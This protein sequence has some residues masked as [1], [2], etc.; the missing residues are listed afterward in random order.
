LSRDAALA[1][2]TSDAAAILEMEN[3]LGSLEVGKLG[4][5]VVMTGPFDHAQS[6]VRYLLV[7]G[8][9]FEYNAKAKPVETDQG[10]A[11]PATDL[12]GKWNLTIDSAEGKVVAVLE[13][14]QKGKDLRGI[15]TSEQ[16]NGTLTSGSIVAEQ[17]EFVVAIGAGARTIRLKFAGLLKDNKLAGE[18]KA[19][20]GAATKWRAEREQA[21]P[22]PQTSTSGS[23]IT[24][25]S[26]E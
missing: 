7:D 18:L 14:T 12:A 5:A 8:Q 9:K 10:D 17:V 26:F 6:K 19:P 25:M 22:A 23:A 24:G 20:F 11:K 15:F 4:H 1:A 21:S 3:R 13:L 2:L 16:G